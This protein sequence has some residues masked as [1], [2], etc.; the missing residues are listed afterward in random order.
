MSSFVHGLGAGSGEQPLW[1]LAAATTNT[2]NTVRIT[3]DNLT[4]YWHHFL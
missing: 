4:Q 1:E 2:P 3:L